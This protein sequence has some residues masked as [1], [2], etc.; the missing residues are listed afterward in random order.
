[1]Q[2]AKVAAATVMG[3]AVAAVLGIFAGIMLTGSPANAPAP[4]QRPAG[5][6]QPYDAADPTATDTSTVDPTTTTTTTN[7]PLLPPPADPTT[8]EPTTTAVV[9]PP[10][11]VDPTTTTNTLPSDIKASP[12]VPTTTT[13]NPPRCDP[14]GTGQQHCNN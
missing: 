11:T 12:I 2:K 8:T 10:A 5:Y 13:V 3:A 9:P 14:D 4:S 7:P 1:M 6:V